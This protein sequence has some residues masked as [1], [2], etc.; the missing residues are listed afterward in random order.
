MVVIG[1]S[2]F[3][4]DWY[5][6]WQDPVTRWRNLLTLPFGLQWQRDFAQAHGKRIAVDEWAAS[7]RTDGHGGG[8]N[9]Y[10]I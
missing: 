9:P 2:A 5:P 8:D 10:Y 7:I 3:D 1:I 6:G 4:Q